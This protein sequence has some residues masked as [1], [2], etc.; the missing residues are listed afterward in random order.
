MKTGENG[1]IA[2]ENVLEPFHAIAIEAS[3]VAPSS[4]ELDTA[5]YFFMHRERGAPAG[6]LILARPNATAPDA[7]AGN[8]VA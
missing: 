8:T 3:L 4:R 1:K 7:K 2:R 5:P 6:L